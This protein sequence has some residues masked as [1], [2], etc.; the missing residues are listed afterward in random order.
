M[1]LDVIRVKGRWLFIHLRTG[2]K[3]T[4][5][6]YLT[7]GLRPIWD[8]T[9]DGLPSWY[10]VPHLMVTCTT[11][12]ELASRVVFESPLEQSM[13]V[14]NDPLILYSCRH[15]SVIMYSIKSFQFLISIQELPKRSLTLLNDTH[16]QELVLGSSGIIPFGPWLMYWAMFLVIVVLMIP[17]RSFHGVQRKV[18]GS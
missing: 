14:F 17:G 16:S 9:E 8:N 11:G 1:Q 7:K 3:G 13:K 15:S 4:L 6:S 2:T 18:T 10:T 5:C 12:F